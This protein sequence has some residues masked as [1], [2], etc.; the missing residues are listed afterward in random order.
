MC[1]IQSAAVIQEALLYIG[2]SDTAALAVQLVVSFQNVR[3]PPHPPLLSPL[4]D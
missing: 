3:G 2:A 4:G 1:Y